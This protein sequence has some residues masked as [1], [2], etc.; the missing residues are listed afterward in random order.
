MVEKNE[1]PVADRIW[2]TVNETM[3]RNSIGR[4]IL[5][6]IL[7]KGLIEARKLGNKT[8]IKR[9]SADAYFASLP[10]FGKAA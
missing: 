1:K 7:A 9:P 10:K 4:T 5:Y 2:D 6:E 3:Q 8:L